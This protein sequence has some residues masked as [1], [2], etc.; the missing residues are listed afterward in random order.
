MNQYFLLDRFH[1]SNLIEFIKS[2]EKL[3]TDM[4]DSETGIEFYHMDAVSKNELIDLLENFNTLD[5][6]AQ[7]DALQDYEHHKQFGVESYQFEP[8]WVE[9][10]HNKIVIGYVGS[11]VNTDFELVFSKIDGQWVL[12][13]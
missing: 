7:D 5:N 4:T 12:M 2:I 10:A 8:S 1:F 11:Y 6:L 3:P 13:K 9:I